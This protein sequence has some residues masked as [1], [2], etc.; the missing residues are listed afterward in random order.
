MGTEAVLPEYMAVGGS[1]ESE[2]ESEHE[3]DG[4]EGDAPGPLEIDQATMKK[5]KSKLAKL[6]PEAAGERGVIY[7]GNIPFGFYED[8]MKA[9]FTQ[10]G[11]VTR[12]RMSRSKRSGRSR[13]YAFVEFE[14]KEVGEIVAETMNNYLLFN[15]VLKCQLMAADQV[16]DETFKNAHRAF[17]HIDWRK[18]EQRQH[19]KTRS[20]EQHTKVV[21]RLRAKEDKKRTQ[22]KELGIEYDFPGYVW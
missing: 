5:T 17:R 3:H 4:E 22:L 15:R 7:I 8:E 9:F 16:H 13:G 6:T 11:G 14:H 1:S 12:L 21:T 2:S 20:T 18:V 19:N 10:F